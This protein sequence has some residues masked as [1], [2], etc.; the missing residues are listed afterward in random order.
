MLSAAVARAD[1]AAAVP[2]ASAG[3]LAE[4]QNGDI[5]WAA[6]KLLALAIP[7]FFFVTVVSVATTEKLLNVHESLA[8]SLI[9]ALI[10]RAPVRA[11][12][13]CVPKAPDPLPPRRPAR[14]R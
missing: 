4:V 8:L 3:A 1:A 10:N 14:Q 9:D 7:V 2:V 12:P 11:G 13:R 6:A 5:L